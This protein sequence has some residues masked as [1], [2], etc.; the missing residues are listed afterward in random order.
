MRLRSIPQGYLMTSQMLLTQ[1][2]TTK[3]KKDSSWKSLT[4]DLE[5]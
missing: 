5:K 1:L 4:R 2:S 3:N